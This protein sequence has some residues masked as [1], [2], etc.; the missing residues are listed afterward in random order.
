M[1]V[2][3]ARYIFAP[4]VQ[5]LRRE[6]E[7]VVLH[8]ARLQE[9]SRHDL[10]TGLGNRL[11]FQERLDAS[12]G[13]RPQHAAI[14]EPRAVR[15]STGSSRST[16]PS[17]TW[18][19]THCCRRSRTGPGRRPVPDAFVARLG[20]DEFGILSPEADTI[21]GME[22]L[23]ARVKQAVEQE[24][25]FQS[26]CL[27][28]VASFGGALL[29]GSGPE[30][31]DWLLGAA[32]LAV[33]RAKQDRLGHAIFNAEMRAA[34]A[35]ERQ[36][37]IDLKRA[38]G[39]AELQVYFQPQVRLVDRSII[40]FEALIRWNHPERGLL[41]PGLFLSCAEQHGLMTD[42]TAFVVEQVAASLR[43]WIKL[44]FDPGI[45]AINVPE[46]M[47]ATPLARQTIQLALGRHRL[48]H[49]RI[50]VEVTEN[51]LL[52]RNAGQIIDTLRSMQSDG[53]RVSFDDFGTGYASL[54][55]LKSFPLDEIKID[56]SFINDLL[57]EESSAEIVRS[58]IKLAAKLKKTVVAEGIETEEQLQF[59]LEE[60]CAIGQGYLF[61]RPVPFEQATELLARPWTPAAC[62]E[63]ARRRALIAV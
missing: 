30:R 51:V 26:H 29:S 40:G 56:R 61:S 19:A 48:D 22:R 33:I 27:Q 32:D 16:T 53:A 38:I 11:A 9:Q 24:V 31:S 37:A 63:G 59:L 35:A 55:H 23:I 34:A 47:L 41:G 18:P 54:S 10:L 44:G 13:H 45:V 36:L 58:L 52:N 15:P 6:H 62:P 50:C 5:R 12:V 43:G 2:L 4:L 7:Q 8:Q 46:S 57:T 21:G 1:L 60:G 14:H 25:P 39:A 3:E 17:G 42:L 49:G 20:G 28:P